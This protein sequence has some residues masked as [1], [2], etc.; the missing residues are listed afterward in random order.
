MLPLRA[1]AI[2]FEA[3]KPRDRRRRLRDEQVDL[4]VACGPAA[5]CSTA[6]AALPRPWSTEPRA[7]S[8]ESTHAASTSW[9]VAP[10]W[11]VRR[12]ASSVVCDDGAALG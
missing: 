5:A 11:W 9:P 4:L 7:P 3:D 6:G 8:N 12:G 10:P 2:P 1:T